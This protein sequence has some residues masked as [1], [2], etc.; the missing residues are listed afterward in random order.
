MNHGG[1]DR[2]LTL[3][4]EHPGN[5]EVLQEL[6]DGLGRPQKR[7]PSKYFYDETGSA[8]FELIT[9]LP[10]YYLTAAERE[11]MRD[12]AADIGRML[13]RRVML[14]ELG[15]GSSVKTRRLLDHLQDPAAYV[16]VDIS[17]EHLERAANELAADYPG[18]AVLPVC[19]DFLQPFDLPRIADG[20]AR[21]VVYFP[22][23]T[24]GNFDPPTV[25]ELMRGVVAMVGRGGRFLVGFDLLKDRAVLERAYDDSQGVT[26]AF[27][28]NLLARLNR[29]FGADFDLSQFRHRAFF[30]EARRCVEMHLVSVREQTVRLAGRPFH[31]RAGETIHTEDSFKHTVEGFT[32]LAAEAG[33]RP[34]AHWTDAG[35]RFCVMLLTATG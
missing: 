28:L 29:E 30:N 24:I 35:R 27:N 8:L 34:D 6:L 17:R 19:A 23:S 26:A 5:G 25:V 3:I 18:L 10:E 7:L 32:A 4:D 33:M 2:G 15:S 1:Q 20:P 22:G 16:P 13:G 31:F 14:V 12:H 11:I 21:P 9:G